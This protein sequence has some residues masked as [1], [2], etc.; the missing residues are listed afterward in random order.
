MSDVVE[1]ARAAAAAAQ[2][3]A[4]GARRLADAAARR[5]EELAAAVERAAGQAASAAAPTGA[6]PRAGTEPLPAGDGSAAPAPDPAGAA[7]HATT[8]PGATTPGGTATSAT[9][10]E[11]PG[12]LG[13]DAVAAVRAGY[14]VAGTALELGALVNGGPRPDVQVRIPLGMLNRH[15]L[16]AGATGTGKTRTL[17]LLAEQA[18]ASGVPVFAADVKG[19]LSGIAAPGQPSERLLARTVAIGQR[20]QGLASPVEFY[21]LGGQGTGVPIRATVSGFGPLLL[22]KVLGLNETQESSLGL[23]FHHAERAGLPLVDL[24]DLR[25]VL[26]FLVSDQGKAELAELGGLSKQ[27][28]GVIL[29]ELVTFAD[30]GAD[31]FFGAPEIDTQE[32]LRTAPDGRGIV[33]LLEVPGVQDRPEVFSTFL[34]W[35]LADLFNELPEVGD[36]DRPRLVFFF[37][38]AHLLFAGASKDFTAQIVR[39]VRLIR[40]KGVGIVF[41]TQT[42]K[43]VPDDVLAQLGS[44]V[45]HQLRAHTPDDAKALRATVSTYPTSDYDLA[46][47]LTSLATGEAI[48]TVMNEDGAPTPVAWTRLRAPQGSME[49]LPAAG[50]EARVASSPLLARYGT[51]VDPESAREVL[52]ARLESAAAQAAAA[53]AQVEAEAEA[54]RAAAAAAE[55]SAAQTAHDERERAAA[56]AAYERAQREFERAERAAAERRSRSTSSRSTSSGSSS[57]RRPRPADDA[58]GDLLGPGLGR[59]I[60]KEVVR[61][62]FSTLRRRR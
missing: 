28:A 52:A 32:F 38:E 4:E 19:D 30:A 22:S 11:P 26:T 39:T 21:S 40:S 13:P 37:D 24:S 6:A 1:Q 36:T 56:Q 25:A 54:A 51:A 8:E 27:T 18:A 2:A 49:P 41:V 60:A 15:G 7:P 47:V 10:T 59:T 44:R 46:E 16:V 42:P 17:Q 12:P 58:L 35:L 45:Q 33:S 62:I 3:A 31:R 29:R 48:V 50:L 14:A 20:W 53:R 55:E 23:V 5:A 57:R 34:M 9:G 43:D 61:G